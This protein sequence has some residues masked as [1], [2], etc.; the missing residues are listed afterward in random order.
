MK[1]MPPIRNERSRPGV[2]LALALCFL[3]HCASA[4]DAPA[5]KALRVLARYPV[6]ADKSVASDIRWASDTSI[7]LSRARDGVFEYELGKQLVQRRQ[8]VPDAV[9]LRRFSFFNRLAASDYLAFTS[10][11]DSLIWRSLERAPDAK[12]LFERKEIALMEDLDLSGDR[13]LFLGV[14]SSEEAKK[15]IAWTGSL[16]GGLNDLTPVLANTDNSQALTNCSPH[17]I[18]A[19]RFLENGSFL[20][21]PG[22]Q[23]GAYLFAPD[24][25]LAR[26]YSQSE[27]TLTTD[28]SGMSREFVADFKLKPEVI[29]PWLNQRRVLDDI[30]PLP[31]GPALLVRY[32]GNDGKIHWDLKVLQPQGIATYEVPMVGHR[33]FARLHGDVRSGKIVLLMAS[34]LTPSEKAEH[35]P[36]E[37]YLAE[38]PP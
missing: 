8:V 30:L 38:L 3:P 28:C 12:I 7:F 22:F 33:P 25:K 16:K 17:G 34:W 24:G 1:S 4:G 15:G 23:P 6:P 37:I 11:G 10:G 27:L 9:T 18:G 35:Q 29:T 21:V 19:V 5:G 20:V 14:P 2:W 36:A 13:V 32:K 31:Q 26:K